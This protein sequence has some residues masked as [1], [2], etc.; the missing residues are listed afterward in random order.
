[1]KLLAFTA[2]GVLA[3]SALT[4]VSADAQ[5]RGWHDNRGWHGDRGGWRGDRNWRG[6]DN[7][8]WRGHGRRHGY[9]YRPRQRVQCRIVRGYYGPVRRC[10]NVWR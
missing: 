7:R 6:R 1:M 4:P 3:A 9:R 10:F 5:R 2:A 8:R